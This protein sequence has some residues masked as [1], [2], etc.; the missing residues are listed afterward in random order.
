MIR[1]QTI[2]IV[3]HCSASPPS[4]DIGADEIRHLHTA[5]RSEKISWGAYT[6]HGKAFSDLGYH[7]VVRRSGL[8]ELGRPMGNI[9]A[10]ARGFNSESFAICMV[11]GV[12]EDGKAETNFTQAQWESVDVAVLHARKMH[13][14]A[15][16]LGHRDLSPDLDGDGV[17][18]SH[19]WTKQC[20]CFEAQERWRHLNVGLE[21]VIV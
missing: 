11:G 21:R 13:P 19:E 18:K 8:I 5:P 3:V 10:H 2:L 12:T 20:P 16:I 15:W 1:Q 17:I 14:D 7:Q 6:L 4:M 9:G